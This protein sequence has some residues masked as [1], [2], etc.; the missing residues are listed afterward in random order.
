MTYFV[1]ALFIH[2]VKSLRPAGQPA[3]I[4][5]PLGLAGD[6]RWMLIDAGGRFISQREDGRL[7]QIIAAPVDGGLELTV[8]DQLKVIVAEPPVGAPRVEAIIWQ[9]LLAL[10]AAPEATAPLSAYLGYPARLVHLPADVIRHANPVWAGAN[11]PV[12]LADAYP[13]LVATS[14]S[15]AALNAAIGASG[16]APVPM[17]R[18]RPNIVI[19]AP[20]WAETQWRRIR[21]GEVEL[22]LIKPSDRCI[23][24]TT[25]QDSGARMGKEPLATLARIRRSADPRINGVLFGENAVV[26]QAGMVRVGDRVSVLKTGSAWPLA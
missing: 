9:H 11:S 15:L 7:A 4:V 26:R 25:D 14:G 2:P 24:T 12:S 8:P 21:L 22:E 19:D 13:V 5:T 3:A 10:P 6:R 17:A 20:A 1:D 16:G 23:V 18:F